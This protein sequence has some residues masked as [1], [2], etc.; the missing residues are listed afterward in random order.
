VR[1]VAQA[2]DTHLVRQAQDG[3]L[4]AYGE[5]ADRHGKVAYRVAL[6]L[7]G[8]HH[9][10]ED[11]AQEAL[12]AAWQHL[13]CYRAESSFPTWLYQIV[14]RRALN[15][16]TRSPATSS[17]DL[18]GDIAGPGGQPAAVIE[19]NQTVDAV[20]AAIAALPLPQRLVI[21]LHHLEGLPNDEVADITAST[22]PAVRSHLFRGRRTL[23]RTLAAW[24]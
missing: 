12:L 3:Y 14:T 16:I 20:A 24:R 22:V 19:R 23:T 8:N 18:L 21:V 4:D 15:Q 13:D 17:L 11:I 2:E 5:L 6:R 1:A 7:V 9:D 10:A